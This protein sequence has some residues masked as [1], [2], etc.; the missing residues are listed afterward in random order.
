MSK[1]ETYR[2]DGVGGQTARED[3]EACAREIREPG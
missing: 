2:R 3:T 1:G